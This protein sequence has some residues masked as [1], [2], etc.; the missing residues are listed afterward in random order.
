MHKPEFIQENDLHKILWDFE[1]Q[2]GHL[3]L[4]RRPELVIVKKKQKKRIYR[5]VVDFAVPADYWVK[6]K[7]SEK[8][9]K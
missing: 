9:D 4:A 1:N 2:T 7:E 6:L 3:I 5:I 8:S